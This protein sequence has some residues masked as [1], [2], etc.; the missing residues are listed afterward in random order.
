MFRTFLKNN[1]RRTGDCVWIWIAGCCMAAAMMSPDANA[2]EK[3]VSVYPVGA[4]TVLPGLT[5]PRGGNALDEF[6]LYYQAN[7]LNTSSGAS[8]LPEFKVRVFANAVKLVHSWNVPVFGGSLNSLIVAPTFYEQLHVASGDYSKN[9]L[10]NV[11]VGVFA[12]GYQKDS[13][14]W[15]YE[16]D[17]YLPGAPYV[18]TDVLNIGQNNYGAAPVGGFTF[19]PRHAE[20]EV[21]S[22]AQYIVNFHDASTHY[23]SGNEVTW[24]YD[25]MKQLSRNVA[26]GVN[27]YLYKQATD[28]RQNGVVVGDGNR[29]RDLAIGPEARLPLGPH[30]ALAFKYFRDTLVQNKPSGNAFWFELGIP[31]SFGLGGH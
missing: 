19:L 8:A 17:A 20:W 26:I 14:H 2:T 1:L 24:E 11:I 18:K 28:D 9:G 30:G 10:G 23:R 29:G 21:S 27:G 4:D 7:R 13:W 3:G 16:G 5:P 12:V 25:V 31:L 22:K 15:F 6:T